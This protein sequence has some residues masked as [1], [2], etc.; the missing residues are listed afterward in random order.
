MR[1]FVLILLPLSLCAHG[2]TA[3]QLRYVFP[4]DGSVFSNTAGA[5]P[6]KGTLMS[7]QFEDGVPFGL[8]RT[9]ENGTVLWAKRYALQS[10]LIVTQQAVGSWGGGSLFS[11]ANTWDNAVSRLLLT[12]TD[13]TGV[14]I[15]TYQYDLGDGTY[16][17]ERV[18]AV[19]TTDDALLINATRENHVD[20]LKVDLSGNVLWSQR[21][22]TTADGVSYCNLKQCIATPDGG[23]ACTGWSFGKL[24]VVRL[25]GD[26]TIEWSRSFSNGG[27]FGASIAAAPDGSFVVGGTMDDGSGL[28]LNVD[29]EGDQLWA[30]SYHAPPG[31]SLYFRSVAV[32]PQG[33]IV[34]NSLAAPWVSLPGM[35]YFVHTDPQG[36]VLDHWRIFSYEMDPIHNAFITFEEGQFTAWFSSEEI[37][38]SPYWAN[39][40]WWHGPVEE[41]DMC[42]WGAVTIADELLPSFTVTEDVSLMTDMVEP[43]SLA[44]SVADVEVQVVDLCTGLPTAISEDEPVDGYRCLMVRSGEEVFLPGGITAERVCVLDAAGRTVLDRQDAHSFSTAGWSTGIYTLHIEAAIARERSV[45]RLAVD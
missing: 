4:Q 19:A 3:S 37:F 12:R 44:I 14:P 13:L 26:G 25:L 11:L 17:Y 32:D 9:D 24:S 29:A 36:V 30:R 7:L 22:N 35:Y 41:P 38:G 8:M 6:D 20:L 1:G 10:G 42:Q 15:W 31:Q 18:G 39:I 43:T 16:D 34:L 21:M 2:Q 27:L 40:N 45:L 23:A 33:E 5:L 28:V